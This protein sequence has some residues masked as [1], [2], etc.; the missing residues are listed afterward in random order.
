MA[1]S[2]P[3]PNAPLGIMCPLYH[4]IERRMQYVSLVPVLRFAVS[5]LNGVKLPKIWPLRVLTVKFI[6]VILA[7]SS[8]LP[9]GVEGPMIHMGALVAKH[10]SQN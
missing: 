3:L 4:G 1:A 9:S 10:V 2:T 7:V 8:G 6:S 5:F